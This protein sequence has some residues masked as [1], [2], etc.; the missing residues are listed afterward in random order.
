MFK[1]EPNEMHAAFN[2]LWLMQ[3]HNDNFYLYLLVLVPLE[4]YPTYII[5]CQYLVKY[6]FFEMISYFFS[7]SRYSNEN[8]LK[9]SFD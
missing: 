9:K 6:K 8:S 7:G 2:V 3:K 4:V 5:K 1:V